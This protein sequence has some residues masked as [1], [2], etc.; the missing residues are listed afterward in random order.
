MRQ[1]SGISQ[2]G[3][4]M[5]SY[6]IT[7][8]VWKMRHKANCPHMLLSISQK[9]FSWSFTAMIIEGV[10]MPWPGID[11]K[12]EGRQ[13]RQS[14]TKRYP[15][16]KDRGE[17][18]AAKAAGRGD[19]KPFALPCVLVLRM[20]FSLWTKASCT[21]SST[22]H[23]QHSCLSCCISDCLQQLFNVVWEIEYMYH[24]FIIALQSSSW[25]KE[26]PLFRADALFYL[27]ICSWL[28]LIC[29]SKI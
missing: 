28:T 6:K 8:L 29:H 10:S 18:V 2:T 27:L 19:S 20:V 24:F 13:G 11:I 22:A 25:C 5:Q 4:E 26:N 14:Q 12:L 3:D 15:G 9:D 23:M 7:T 1:S 17:I 16:S 21:S